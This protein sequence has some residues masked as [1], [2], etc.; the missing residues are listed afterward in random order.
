MKE[1]LCLLDS[2]GRAGAGAVDATQRA[3]TRS[4][5]EIVTTV[6]NLAA[7]RFV[8]SEDLQAAVYG[9]CRNLLN[10]AATIEGAKR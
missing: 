5:L 7:L 8:P 9:A 4:A 2:A 10:Q 1:L 3:V 6:I